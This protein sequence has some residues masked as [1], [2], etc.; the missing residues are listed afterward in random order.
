MK[1]KPLSENRHW[2]ILELCHIRV[3]KAQ[4]KWKFLPALFTVDIGLSRTPP[5]YVS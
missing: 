5:I 2:L 3:K 4:K 1:L